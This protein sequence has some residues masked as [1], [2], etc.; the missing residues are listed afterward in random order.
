[1]VHSYSSTI[2]VQNDTVR[3][4]N[5]TALRSSRARLQLQTVTITHLGSL[6]FKKY[7][8]THSYTHTQA[9]HTF[10]SH[11]KNTRPHLTAPLHRVQQYNNT[12]VQQYNTPNTNTAIHC[13]HQYGSTKAVQQYSSYQHFLPL[14]F[15]TTASIRHLPPTRARVVGRV[16]AGAAPPS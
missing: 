9:D 13:S 14:Q 5:S 12:A 4:N 16:S 15:T 3:E 8:E 1:M 10:S 2:L 11:V 6:F 7:T